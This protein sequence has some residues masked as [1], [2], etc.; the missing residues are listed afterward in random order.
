MRSDWN[1]HELELFATGTK[2]NWRNF[3]SENTLEFETRVRG[4]IDI[5]SRTSIEGGVRYEQAM[6]GRGSTELP[7]AASKPA[8]THET[9]IFGQINHRFNR[10]GFRI[11]GQIT[12]NIFDD[13]ALNSGAIQDNSVRNYDEHELEV[14]TNYEFSPR[15]SLFVDSGL[16]TRK[17]AQELDGSGFVQ[18][19]KNWL[20]AVGANMELSPTL[21][22]LGRIGYARANPDEA[23]YVDLE[24]VI[25]DASLIWAPTRLMSATLRGETQI[26]ETTQTGTPGSINRSVSLE[27]ANSWTH[28]LNSVVRSEFE[29][30]DYAGI[31][32][33][34]RELTLG[35]ELEYLL[36]RSWVLNA[37][38][39][40]TLVEGSNSYREDEF[41]LGVKW[42]R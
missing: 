15:L 37:G 25:Y 24:G 21:S 28:R 40:H 30:R 39:E 31:D 9:E 10:L 1:N 32:Q 6:E 20:V 16:G 22:F 13:V 14:R 12:R 4:R 5:T 3:I 34:D 35:L 29:H 42:R 2:T 36:S 17:F 19:S 7:D 33:T 11:R 26:E 23:S 38:Y 18:G 41:S 27:L 8:K